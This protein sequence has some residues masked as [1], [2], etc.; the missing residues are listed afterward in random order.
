[1]K[2]S[3]PRIVSIDPGRVDPLFE[4]DNVF[5]RNLFRGSMGSSSM[6]GNSE[7]GWEQSSKEQE[8]AFDCLHDVVDNR[9]NRM[10]LEE[11]KMIQK[12]W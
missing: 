11:V 12:W 10:K 9:K 7:Y 2:I 3:G 8:S 6:R 1:M 5:A 4:S